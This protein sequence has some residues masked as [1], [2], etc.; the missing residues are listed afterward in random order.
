MTSRLIAAALLSIIV[1]SDPRPYVLDTR[2]LRGTEL[3][4]DHHLP[5]TVGSHYSAFQWKFTLGCWR[6]G[7]INCQT[8][9]SGGALWFSPRSWVRPVDLPELLRGSWQF[10]HPVYM[11]LVDLE[12]AYDSVP[13]GI[14]WGLPKEYGVPELLLLAIESLYNQSKSFVRIL[15]KS[16][17][18]C[19]SG[20]GV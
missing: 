17:S 5:T 14:L 15:G 8:F 12:K 1:S 10:D 6:G 13:W 4:T 2:V 16:K 11:C 18:N 9:N 19:A 20:G 7:L 3:S